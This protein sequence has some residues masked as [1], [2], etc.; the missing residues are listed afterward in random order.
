[1][2]HGTA[3]TSIEDG[4]DEARDVIS[5]LEAGGVSME[6]VTTQLMHDGVKAFADSF[7]ELI[8]NIVAKRD[9]LLSALAVPAGE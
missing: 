4:A 2:E 6:A 5:A 9:K 7:D 3:R 8:E 1:M